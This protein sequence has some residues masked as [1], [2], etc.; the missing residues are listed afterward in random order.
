MLAAMVLSWPGTQFLPSAVQL[1]V[2]QRHHL[3]R[4]E[5]K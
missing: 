1:Y 5:R 4:T 3:H 2:R